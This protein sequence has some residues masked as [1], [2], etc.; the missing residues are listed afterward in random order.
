MGTTTLLTSSSRKSTVCSRTRT[1]GRIEGPA[2][3]ASAAPSPRSEAGESR[4][5]IT[6]TEGVGATAAHVVSATPSPPRTGLRWPRQTLSG[7]PQPPRQQRPH[8]WPT[9]LG[10]AWTPRHPAEGPPGQRRPRGLGGPQPRLM[11]PHTSSRP[12]RWS[13]SMHPPCASD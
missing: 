3:S 11:T 6:N 8:V 2:S 10:Q 7:A 5:E 1:S 4:N 12:L 13:R 9:P